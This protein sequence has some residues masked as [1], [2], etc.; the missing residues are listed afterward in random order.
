MLQSTTKSIHLILTYFL[1]ISGLRAVLL[2]GC[3]WSDQ[4]DEKELDN[5][6]ISEIWSKISGQQACCPK[7]PVGSYL[8][9]VPK[10]GGTS[11]RKLALAPFLNA[12][13]LTLC[14][15]KEN[16][17]IVGHAYYN[18]VIPIRD[19][20]RYFKQIYKGRFLKDCS[21]IAS[22][23]DATLLNRLDLGSR[24]RNQEKQLLDII[25][26]RKPAERQLSELKFIKVSMGKKH[27]S[28]FDDPRHK[29][30]FMNWIDADGNKITKL[31]S[32]FYGCYDFSH[33][34]RAGFATES[35]VKKALINLSQFCAIL[36][37]EEPQCGLARLSNIFYNNVT[38][39]SY[40][41]TNPGVEYQF[42]T[43]YI[44]Q[45]NASNQL[46]DIV[47][48]YALQLNRQQCEQLNLDPDTIQFT[49]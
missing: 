18:C 39:Q 35:D 33:P 20:K 36:I 44:K 40:P 1:I 9:H 34:L 4:F 6:G 38:I 15:H 19:K 13:G 26:L 45:A 2:K 24:N 11:V 37:L 3:G 42:H 17:K 16:S 5:L 48:N 10:S 43:D 22:H 25:V 49:E 14:D 32:G 47:Y 27:T 46:D 8:F 28:V 12:G 29:Q 21:V 31:L 23:N 30:K 41:D 7:N